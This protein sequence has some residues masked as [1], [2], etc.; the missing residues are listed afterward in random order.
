V[1]SEPTIVNRTMD[2]DQAAP[3]LASRPDHGFVVVWGD[4][5]RAPPDTSHGAVRARLLSP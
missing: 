5:S 2:G 4:G 1:V 3:S